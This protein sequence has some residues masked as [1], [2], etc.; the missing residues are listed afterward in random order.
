M[1]LAGDTAAAVGCDAALV[2]TWR[3]RRGAWVTA[4]HVSRYR[5]A[6]AAPGF[7]AVRIT[8]G[9]R[10][11]DITLRAAGPA[12][13]SRMDASRRAMGPDMVV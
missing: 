2:V 10:T 12:A 6:D 9:S 7:Q 8:L 1:E 3:S 11:D 5:F 13:D 4:F